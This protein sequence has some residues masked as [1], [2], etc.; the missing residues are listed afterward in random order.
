MLKLLRRY[1]KIILVFGGCLL[2]I[3]F[4][5]P[6]VGMQGGGGGVRKGET[7]ARFDGGRMTAGDYIRSQRELEALTIV[8]F[9]DGGGS[10][11]AE[12]MGIESVEHWFLLSMLAEQA[13][14]VGGPQD[15]RALL[16]SLAED[17]ANEF[18][19]RQ[20]DSNPSVPRNQFDSMVPVLRDSFFQNF[21]MTREAALRRAGQTEDWIDTTLSKAYGVF[22]M[23]G[24]SRADF[25]LSRAEA[26][27]YG[28][29]L[30]DTAVTDILL[31]PAESVASE[32]TPPDE[33]RIAAH[34]EK[35]RGVRASEDPHNIGYRR[36]PAVRLEFLSVDN[37]ILKS[38]IT[39]DPIEVNKFWRQNRANFPGE[40]VEER[41][42]VEAEFRTR[43]VERMLQR[44]REAT[45]SRIKLALSQQARTGSEGSAAAPGISIEDVAAI[46]RRQLGEGPAAQSPVTVFPAGEQWQDA[47]ELNRLPGIPQSSWRATDRLT[48]PFLQVVMSLPELGAPPNPALQAERERL[49]VGAPFGPLFDPAGNMYYY[50]VVE[51][52]AEGPAE[53][54]DEVRERILADIAALDGLALLE[55]RAD[56]LRQELADKGLGAMLDRPGANFRSVIDT[57]ITNEFLRQDQATRVFPELDEPGLRSAVMNRVM[58][59]PPLK[60]VADIPVIDRIVAVPNTRLRSLVLVQIKSRYPMTAEQVAAN[61]GSI[62]S[63]ARNMQEQVRQ[64]VADSPFSFTRLAERTGFR[65]LGEETA[66]D[67]NPAP[68]PEG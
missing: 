9:A 45:D 35:Y 2:M 52:R 20:A 41:P 36:A 26:I 29:R 49:R 4:L 51:A 59:W 63:L 55:T 54:I 30:F 27:E 15:G 11:L 28:R 66:T 14:L 56:Q 18:V 22:R 58:G 44:V 13:G 1:N 64:E 6:S 10:T 5:V 53:S 40:F 19:R 31:I 25:S 65:I 21:E 61:E 47:L 68:T 62:L 7:I 23:I 38:G 12:F 37:N 43:E 60:E 67:E 3:V 39:L 46:I 34:F 32:L 24:A 42:I 50:R 17:R 16:S 57:R 48:L 33:A 8:R